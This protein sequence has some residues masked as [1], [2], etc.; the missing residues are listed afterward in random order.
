M[1]ND[2][3]FLQKLNK[4][5]PTFDIAIIRT[6]IDNS[7]FQRTFYFCPPAYTTPRRLTYGSLFTYSTALCWS[8]MSLP[9]HCRLVES[10]FGSTKI[11]RK[12]NKWFFFHSVK[13][14]RWPTYV[15]KERGNRTKSKASPT[16]YVERRR[17]LSRFV[18]LKAP[19]VFSF[20]KSKWA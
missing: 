1:K 7:N 15:W 14:T 9:I 8:G 2:I 3:Y 18:A 16:F 13:S 11:E 5:V 12:E 6:L 4:N 17:F 20:L 19:A 10:S